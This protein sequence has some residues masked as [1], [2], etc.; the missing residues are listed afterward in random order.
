M[1]LTPFQY[2]WC[3]QLTDEMISWPLCL[4]FV[5]MVDP[6]LDGAPD[7]FDVIKNPMALSIVKKKL[8]ENK[9][10]KISAWKDDVNL[11]WDNAIKYNGDETLFALM[12]LEAKLWFNKKVDK[13]PKTQE[14][15]LMRKICSL[16][17]DLNSL[18]YFIPNYIPVKRE[19]RKQRKSVSEAV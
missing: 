1:P 17:K 14:D 15:H 5:N 7:Y 10:K 3:L 6:E 2:D 16:K 19:K 13:I 12:A 4:P 11:I 18:M 8:E 9:Y